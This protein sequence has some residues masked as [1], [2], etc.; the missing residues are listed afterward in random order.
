MRYVL[1]LVTCVFFFLPLTVT[2]QELPLCN[3][4]SIL[5]WDMGS[6]SDLASYRV[7]LSPS[8]LTDRLPELVF[9]ELAKADFQIVTEAS[10]QQSITD[11]MASIPPE[12][13]IY[14]RVTAVDQS[15]NESLFS[16]E[17]GCLFNATPSVPVIRLHLGK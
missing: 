9:H 13:P 14:M 15:G 8:P 16:N 7:Y 3:E 5:M 17:V 1:T 2:A 12:G 10:G 6:E 4:R 11:T